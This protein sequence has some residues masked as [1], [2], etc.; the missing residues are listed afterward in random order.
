MY[1]KVIAEDP[2]FEKNKDFWR[3]MFNVVVGIAWQTSLVAFPIFLVLR[4]WI[5]FIIAIS[6]T[7]VTSLILKFTWW[8]KLKD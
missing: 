7:A 5:P 8:N 3:D 1:K 4:D 6:I 2:S